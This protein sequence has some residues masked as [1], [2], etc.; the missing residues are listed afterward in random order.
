MG[1][2]IS[3]AYGIQINESWVSQLKNRLAHDFPKRQFTVINSSISGD[4][5]ESALTRLP[6]LLKKISPGLL[7][8]ELGGNDGL[9]GI[10]V[11]Q[12]QKN[13]EKMIQLGLKAKQKIILLGL[14]MP[15]NLGPDYTNAFHNMYAK[16]AKKYHLL[17]VPC[18]YA[19]LYIDPKL[20]QADGIHPNAQGQKVLLE[21][22][23]P[24]ITYSLKLTKEKPMLL[25]CALPP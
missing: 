8:I 19:K 17:W 4:T 25:D 20:M 18:I 7:L 13:L 23:Y 16:L 9:R 5:T 2:S 1:D 24:T 21:N 11:E 15:P 12:S 14:R 6:Q 10:K 3:N 22:V